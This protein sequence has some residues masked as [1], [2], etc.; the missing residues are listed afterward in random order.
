MMHRLVLYTVTPSPE[1]DS[2]FLFRKQG[3]GFLTDFLFSRLGDPLFVAL[4]VGQ[5]VCIMYSRQ[6]QQH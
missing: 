5:S 6:Q 2:A 1:I 4:L 3:A